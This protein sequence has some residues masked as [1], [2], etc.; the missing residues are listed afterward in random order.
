MRKILALAL[1]EWSDYFHSPLVYLILTAALA[2]FNSFF[3]LIIDENRE[4]VLADVFRVM[5]FLLV[6]IVPLWTMRS[7]AEEKGRGTVEFLM[8]SPLT[9][10]DIIF[11]KY[12]GHLMF[13]TL[14]ISL[15][16]VYYVIMEF[17]AEP[18]AAPA[19]TGYLGIWLEAA[20]FIAI[21]IFCSALTSS[22]VVAAVLSYAVLSVLY[23]SPVLEKYF[24][25]KALAALKYVGTANHLE[26]FA[27]GLVMLSDVVYYVSGIVLFLVLAVFLLNKR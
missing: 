13:V 11:G 18:D 24:T 14:L 19:L 3:F 4:A 21:G 8:T 26:H 1:K 27:S 20:M 25:G 12:L 15:T 9:G 22:Q 7:V 6:F 2:I 5:E 16:G 17:F 23:F 10:R